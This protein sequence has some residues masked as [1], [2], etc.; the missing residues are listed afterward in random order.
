MMRPTRKSATSHALTSA[1]PSQGIS[2]S[3]LPPDFE[4]D[5]RLRNVA[6]VT[7]AGDDL[8]AL[9]PI[10]YLCIK[11]LVMAVKRHIAITVL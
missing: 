10:A 6:G 7:Q 3:P 9:D 11:A 8:T 2:G 4:I 5:P 1:K